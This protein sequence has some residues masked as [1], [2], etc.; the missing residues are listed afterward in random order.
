MIQRKVFL[1]DKGGKQRK[2]KSDFWDKCAKGVRVL[3]LFLT[4][5]C[6]HF[7]S[8]NKLHFWTLEYQFYL[9][10]LNL[11]KIKFVLF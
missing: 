5:S 8:K 4:K 11:V 7:D 1:H 10:C 6:P 2:V 3:V 9:V